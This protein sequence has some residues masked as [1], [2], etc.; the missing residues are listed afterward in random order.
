M[1]AYYEYS[2]KEIRIANIAKEL[3]RENIEEK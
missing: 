3:I 2:E 1:H